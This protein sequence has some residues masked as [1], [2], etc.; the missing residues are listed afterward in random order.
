[1]PPETP[2]ERFAAGEA[3]EFK[4][5]DFPGAIAYFQELA[6]DEDAAVRAG[7]LLRLA[8]SQRK[9]GQSDAALAT[10]T[11]LAQI[12]DVFIAGW[13]ADLRARKTRCDVLEQ[14][15][16]LAELKEE[17]RT[18]ARDLHVGRWPLTRSTFMSLAES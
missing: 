1:M 17:S 7:A 13:P 3:L 8:R 14:L 9:A 16:R 10:Y 18:L 6:R 5:R 12:R 2:A 11:D 4:D 15:G